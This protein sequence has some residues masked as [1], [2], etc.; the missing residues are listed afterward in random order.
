MVVTDSPPPI[1]LLVA[2]DFGNELHSNS[3]S[4][5]WP[6]G[7]AR[8]A[9][10]KSPSPSA[11]IETAFIKVVSGVNEFHATLVDVPEWYNCTVDLLLSSPLFDFKNIT[12][13]ACDKAKGLRTEFI[14]DDIC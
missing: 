8:I 12:P 14:Y 3:S 10:K 7:R 4:L 5:I 2:D 11:P 1:Y 9:A 6:V 13:N